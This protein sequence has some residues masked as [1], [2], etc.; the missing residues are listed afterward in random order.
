[1]RLIFSALNMAATLVNAG[2]LLAHRIYARPELRFGNGME[3]YGR[4]GSLPYT[5]M[6]WYG[7]SDG[8]S[9]WHGRFVE[10]TTFHSVG[11]LRDIPQ[12]YVMTYDF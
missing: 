4:K 2:W 11:Y 3:C 7:I 9:H 6:V 8:I 12:Q 10:D 5:G 1:M